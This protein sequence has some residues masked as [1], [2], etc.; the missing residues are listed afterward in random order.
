MFQDLPTPPSAE[1]QAL[2]ATDELIATA[3][4][5]INLGARTLSPEALHECLLSPEEFTLI[6]ARD[7]NPNEGTPKA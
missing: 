4:A 6:P 3:Q 2:L 1:Q 5:L 7:G